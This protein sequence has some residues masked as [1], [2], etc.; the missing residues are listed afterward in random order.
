MT[1]PEAQPYERTEVFQQDLAAIAEAMRAG[2]KSNRHDPRIL[3]E[4]VRVC[5]AR[6]RI[7]RC[8]PETLVRTLKALVREVAPDDSTDAFRVL[9]TDRVIAWAIEGYYELDDR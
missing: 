3:H 5:A 1:Q 6:A 8:P 4:S 2:R 7:N 9:Y